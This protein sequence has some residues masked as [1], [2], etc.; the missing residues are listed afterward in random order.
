MVPAHATNGDPEDKGQNRE[1]HPH[2]GHERKFQLQVSWASLGT[3]YFVHFINV[4][5]G[6]PFKL[7]GVLEEAVHL[8]SCLP[9]AKHAQQ[10]AISEEEDERFV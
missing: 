7:D 8:Y 2:N 4:C 3:T 1:N 6:P 5:R 10:G 9:C